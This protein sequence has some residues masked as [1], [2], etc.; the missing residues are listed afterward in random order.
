[1]SKTFR[2]ID[3]IEEGPCFEVPLSQIWQECER[4]GA[5]KILSP[6]KYHSD[7][8]LRWYKGV[9]LRGLSDWNGDTPDEWDL[10]L[11]ADCNGNEL[12]KKQTIYMGYGQTCTRLT[13][14]GVGVRNFTQFIEN[15]LSRSMEMDWPIE[16][17]DP[18]L[19]KK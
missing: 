16:P 8:Q 14:V 7:R 19:R 10:R 15:I 9:A 1:M 12:L 13:T 2:I 11:K 6:L 17:P 4:G 3:V 18:D 5:V